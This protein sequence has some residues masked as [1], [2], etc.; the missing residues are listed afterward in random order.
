MSVTPKQNYIE[1]LRGRIVDGKL[2]L[3]N[4]NLIKLPP[5]LLLTELVGL[6]I[7]NNR[8]DTLPRL[9]PGLVELNISGNLFRQIPKLPDSLKILNISKNQLDSSP[10]V[11]EKVGLPEKLEVL[12]V[13]SCGLYRLPI[14]PPNLKE[15]YCRNNQLTYILELPESLETFE[16]NKESIQRFESKLKQIVE[17]YITDKDMPKLRESLRNYYNT[18]YKPFIPRIVSKKEQIPESFYEFQYKYITE[19]N[20]I[21]QY[22]VSQ[23]SHHGDIILNK[24]LRGIDTLETYVENI[25]EPSDVEE[26]TTHS[27]VSCLFFYLL[28]PQFAENIFLKA[29][30]K[31]VTRKSYYIM[32]T[33][34]PPS[35]KIMNRWP[36][37]YH[38]NRQNIPVGEYR[39]FLN[40]M[41]QTYS[42]VVYPEI[43]L[44]FNDTPQDMLYFRIRSYD[45]FK[46]IFY[47]IQDTVPQMSPEIKMGPGFVVYRGVQSFHIPLLK[48]PIVMNSF[49]STS[50]SFNVALSFSTK[51]DENNDDENN[52]D[53][54]NY[55]ENQVKENNMY[56]FIVAPNVPCLYMETLT[57]HQGEYEVLFP[58]GVRFLHVGTYKRTNPQTNQTFQMFIVLP[59]LADQPINTRVPDTYEEY[60]DWSSRL[61][62]S[63]MPVAPPAE[64]SY[65]TEEDA[66]KISTLHINNLKYMTTDAVPPASNQRGGKKTCRTRRRLRGGRAQLLKPQGN[67]RNHLNKT[68]NMRPQ[69]LTMNKKYKTMQPNKMESNST[70]ISKP[71]SSMANYTTNKGG[72][73]DSMPVQYMKASLTEKEKKYLQMIQEKI[74]GSP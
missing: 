33:H 58:P 20:E 28:A 40:D 12:N 26:F 19:L 36:A 23:Y 66:I 60:M 52:Y 32:S 6:N 73:W 2:V 16:I 29:T 45:A 34:L 67:M 18:K 13:D 11:I 7:S 10:N 41:N 47:A 61:E 44:H 21:Q 72:R 68:R 63:R 38:N 64:N 27:Q 4:L 25:M 54:N 17:T 37:E 3:S 14:L 35:A 24:M 62:W 9:P 5:L 31:G 65:I 22:T 71:A 56:Q 39:Q 30:K 70:I 1:A 57:Y 48:E 49:L 69:K 42:T 46:I 8:L 74:K 50:A 51:V 59:P 55:D 53:E 15:L 43:Q